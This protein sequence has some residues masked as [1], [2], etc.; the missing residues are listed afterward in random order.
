MAKVHINSIQDLK[1]DKRNVNRGTARGAHMLDRSL[2]SYGAGRSILLDRKGQVIAGNKTLEAA[3]R[4]GYKRVV[5]VPSDGTTLVAVQRSDLDIDSKKARELAIADNRIAQVDLDWDP[6]MLASLEVDLKEFWNEDEFA[7]LLAQ[8][9]DGVLVE[10]P[11]PKLD[12]A[13]ELQKKWGTALGQIWEIGKHRLMCG[14]S[15]DP[16]QVA[17]L[18][19]S[20]KAQLLATDPPYLVGYDAKNHPQNF[21][22][23]N[24]N[25]EWHGRYADK[26]K[27][28]PL[29]PFYEGFLKCALDVCDQDAAIYV[30]HASQR[31]VEVEKAMR[32]C[33]ILVHQQ[34][35]W[36]KNKAT[37]T[38]SFYMW[39]HEPCFFGWQQ[40]HKPRRNRGEFPTTV[41]QVDV[42]VLPGKESRHPTEKPLKLFTTP[43]LLH[44]RKGALCYEPFSGSGTC[45]CAAE[46]TGRRCYAMELEPAFA[47]VALERLSEMSLKP[48]LL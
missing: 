27:D 37:L 40:S 17:G 26:Q 32:N 11:E 8:S 9:G 23:N 33:G 18:M 13:E 16:A 47:G 41:W 34:I 5:V 12:Q 43:I 29:G 44:T 42:P 14:D 6:G 48:I 28:E 19:N 35:V 10:A 24:K 25:K 2:A 21:K 36:F 4:A 39:A 30:W 20:E 7:E 38:H 45:L 15:T 31:Q 46:A 3:K 1:L 22:Q